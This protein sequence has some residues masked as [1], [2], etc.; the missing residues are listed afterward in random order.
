MHSELSTFWKRHQNIR[1]THQTWRLSPAFAQTIPQKT[2]PANIDSSSFLVNTATCTIHSSAY[3]VILIALH[4][5]EELTAC[6]KWQKRREGTGGS[7]V[8]SVC[9]ETGVGNGNGVSDHIL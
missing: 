3:W 2:A 8:A 7:G 4:L 9:A 6:V 5:S 1:D